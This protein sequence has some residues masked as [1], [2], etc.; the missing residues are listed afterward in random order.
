M[1]PALDIRHV[2]PQLRRASIAVGIE[3]K[4]PAGVRHFR[5]VELRSVVTDVSNAMRKER[6]TI[7]AE[8]PV[9]T[10]DL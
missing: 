4:L 5:E 10:V 9:A 1:I 2:M 3:S 8:Q 7:R 6:F